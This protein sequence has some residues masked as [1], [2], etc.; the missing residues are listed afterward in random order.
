MPDYGGAPEDHAWYGGRLAP[1]AKLE[2]WR[3]AARTNR[4]TNVV[5]AT[6]GLTFEGGV[7]VCDDLGRYFFDLPDAGAESVYI[8]P[9]GST[10][11]YRI[12]RSDLGQRVA[13]LENGQ[14]ALDSSVDAL[15]T[16]VDSN[17]ATATTAHQIAT[18]LQNSIG[19]ADGLAP[20]DTSGHIPQQYLPA[21]GDM[22]WINAASY[23]TVGDGSA[24]DTGAI[25]GALDAASSAGGGIVWIPGGLYS[26]DG[27]LRIYEGTTLWAAPHAWI[28]RDGPGTMLV[29]GDSAQG[30]G[31]YT[32]HGNILVMGGVWDANG[33]VVSD[34]NLALAFGH[35]RNITVRDVTIR[36]VPGFHAIEMNSTMVGRIINC[37]FEGFVATPGR[38]HSEAV[39]FDGAYRSTVWGAFGPYDD[40][41]CH[42]ILM[43][44]C[45][46]GTS[47]T[48][49]TVGWGRG[50]GSHST[51]PDSPHNDVRI[52]GNHFEDLLEWAV[53]AYCWSGA[54]IADN[55]AR[56]CGA[57]VWARSLDS[58]KTADRT[59]AD[60]TTI[61]G[62]QPLDSL[63]ISN[64]TLDNGTL[65]T[66]AIEVAGEST[67]L[68]RAA[69]IDNNTVL[70]CAGSAVRAEYVQDSTIRGNVSRSSGATAIST[71]FADALT[72]A[73]NR[74]RDAGSAGITL[75]D[76][77]NDC[78]IENNTVRDA[79]HNGIWAQGGQDW[80]MSDN[81]V[82]GAGQDGASTSY[83]FRI[84]T[85]A[86]R[87]SLSGNRV[88]AGSGTIAN[89]IS[90]TSSCDTAQV[91]GN[92][93][94]G[95]GTVDV[96]A[97]NADTTAGNLV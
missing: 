79:Q 10:Q 27:P 78:R 86:Q 16:Q 2:V 37:R 44:G 25:Q 63:T 54:V 73:G 11:S 24:D 26:I 8:S 31:G 45:Y 1:G 13:M 58:S 32:G 88:H 48:A 52:I 66:P 97:T 51:A 87:F 56:D 3:D 83:G 57:L 85:G 82:A 41:P 40:T 9:V 7:I 95:G 38:E 43:Q 71:E 55:T 90:V 19:E 69:K 39:Q 18:D 70:T 50:V 91:Y 81:T 65:A 15:S 96:Q 42:D 59:R 12:D 14:A 60:D 35:C 22:G 49:G 74:V 17:T 76:S 23:G 61:A 33:T 75:I 20:L 94:R 6:T 68:V 5:D 46:V 93:C 67:G 30:M 72:I 34:N 4:I 21:G 80:S 77:V 28:R 36:D 47:G 62:S 53:G 92:D 29:N 89:A 84:T 64:N